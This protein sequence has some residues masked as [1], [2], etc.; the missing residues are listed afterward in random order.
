[1]YGSDSKKIMGTRE[2]H[3]YGREGVMKKNTNTGKYSD[4]GKIPERRPR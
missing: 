4:K 1:M 3:I 2:I